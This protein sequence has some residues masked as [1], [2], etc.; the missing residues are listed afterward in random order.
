MISAGALSNIRQLPGQVAEAL[1]QEDEFP[2]VAIRRIILSTAGLAIVLG[3][4]GIF[5]NSALATI[6]VVLGLATWLWRAPVRGLYLMAAFCALIQEFPLGF[7][8]SLTDRIPLWLNLDASGSGV[9]IGLSPFDAILGTVIVITALRGLFTG[10]LRLSSGRLNA[11]YF[12]YGGALL[13]G[14]LNGMAGGGSLNMAEWAL[15]PQ[16]YGLLVFL[17]TTA[18]LRERR[19]LVT[20]LIVFLTAEMITAILGDWR[21]IVTL[22][23][24]V[25]SVNALLDHAD[26]Y[27]L[28][29]FLV[30]MG[31]VLVW[32]K[33]PRIRLVLLLLAPLPALA[34]IEN[35]RRTGI[36]AAAITFI[37]IMVLAIRYRPNMRK[38]TI[39]IGATLAAAYAAFVAASW[40]V[41]YGTR[42]ALVTPVKSALGQDTGER[43]S[44]S[45]AYR[46][47]ENFNLAFTYHLS[48]I[49]GWGLGKD[50]LQV[51]PMVN[52]GNVYS[53]YL[54][55]PHNSLLW[56]PMAL[57]G[58]GMVAFWALVGTGL[59][60]S[61]NAIRIP[62][63]RLL[64]ATGV[65]CACAIIAELVFAY[66]D[67]Q[68]MNPRNMVTFGIVLGIA[69]VAPRLAAQRRGA[70]PPK[71][72]VR[73]DS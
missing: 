52:I 37:V 68:L 25:S 65:F 53:L 55:L 29:L 31:V 44:S 66:A 47:A 22:Q 41:Q 39:P 73:D 38:F 18:V 5:L 49:T 28:L 67:L 17:V 20:L 45:D 15:R 43:N 71:E 24:N 32:A 21:Y 35:N 48:P 27:F 70:A 4:I 63:D 10:R 56:V 23:R 30:V 50:F 3:A 6:L 58:I 33:R 11:P 16:F 51:M 19:Q 26:S 72:E 8:D 12:I 34:L 2:R 42:A 14:L 7:P 61:I 46:I 69:N 40:N 54:L 13:F 36:D 60:E 1:Q 59:M 9:H 64:Q 57:G 62:N